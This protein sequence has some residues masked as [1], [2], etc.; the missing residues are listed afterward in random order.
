MFSIVSF[1]KSQNNPPPQRAPKP[2]SRP[3]AKW[4]E[5]PRHQRSCTLSSLRLG[6]EKSCR[7][8]ERRHGITGLGALERVGDLEQ[9][10]SSPLKEWW[11]H[12]MQDLPKIFEHHLI[13]IHQSTQKIFPLPWPSTGSPVAKRPSFFP[14]AGVIA[15]A[16]STARAT[17][18][19]ASLISVVVRSPCSLSVGGTAVAPAGAETAL[20]RLSSSW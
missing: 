13:R 19:A 8:R 18:H 14:E 16:P 20:V 1:F 5:P 6:E 3:G 10:E 15:Q 9:T 4:H 11:I 12:D 2:L 17:I 7:Y